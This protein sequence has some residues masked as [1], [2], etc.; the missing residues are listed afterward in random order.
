MKPFERFIRPVSMANIDDSMLEGII[1]AKR[2]MPGSLAN[3][4]Y[5]K[6]VTVEV[7]TIKVSGSSPK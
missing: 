2:T 3:A 6:S 1:F 5:S 7:V 4:S